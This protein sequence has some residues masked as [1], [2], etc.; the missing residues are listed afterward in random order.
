MGQKSHFTRL[1]RD[2]ER[3]RVSGK[4]QELDKVKNSVM[5]ANEEIAEMV[6]R[7]SRL[8][9]ERNN[10]L[11]IVR[12]SAQYRNSI[13][14]GIQYL[15]AM[16]QEV[17]LEND[18]SQLSEEL[19]ARSDIDDAAQKMHESNERLDEFIVEKSRCEGKLIALR[20]TLENLESKLSTRE[21]KDIDE[22][23][24]V[25]MIEFETT[26]IAVKDLEVYHNA[27]DQALLQYHGMKIEDINKIIK[28]LWQVCYKGEDITNIKL[29]SDSGGKA[30]KSYNYRVVMIKNG[31]TQLDMRGRCS[32]GQRVLAAIVIRLALAETFCLNCGVMT[33]D[34]RK[35]CIFPISYLLI[36]FLN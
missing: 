16:K 18:I 35:Y 26:S 22:R 30:S 32:A 3:F 24:R 15:K 36:I 6:E 34:E 13:L 23:H 10:L 28:D 31:S 7:K 33:L 29:V 2:I 12:E 27:L 5:T 11:S 17:K 21:Y 19:K 8:E 14:D 4:D 1:N 9:I 25:K 20:D